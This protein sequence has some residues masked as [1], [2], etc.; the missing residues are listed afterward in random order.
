MSIYALFLAVPFVLRTRREITTLAIAQAGA[1]LAGGIGFLLIPGRLAYAPPRELGI[2]KPLFQFADRLN[3]D[4]N[5]VPSL[6]VALSVACI[7]MFVPNTTAL[8][9]TLLRGWGILIAASTLLT[10]Q[11]HVVDVVTGY[12]LALA[13]VYWARQVTKGGASKNVRKPLK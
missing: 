10:H 6:H 1:I 4:Y 5:L 7:E 3:L 9:K 8:G 12:L 2:W 11:H 13:T